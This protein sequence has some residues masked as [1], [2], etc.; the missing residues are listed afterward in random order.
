MK[1]IPTTEE[2]IAEAMKEIA[3]LFEEYGQA[4]TKLIAN[5]KEID[6][7]TVEMTESAT[8]INNGSGAMKSD[9]LA[10]QKRLEAESQATVGETE[11]L[12]LMLAT[13]AS[14]WVSSGVPAARA[15]PGR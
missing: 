9:L 5:S 11:Q 12:I 4:L 3:A 15:F 2:K 13:G 14:R 8:A 7:L 10:D 6:G 1:V